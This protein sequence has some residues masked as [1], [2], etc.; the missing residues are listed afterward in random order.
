MWKEKYS[1]YI[2]DILNTGDTIN[3]NLSTYESHMNAYF[4][5]Y[6]GTNILL[7]MGNHDVTS[8]NSSKKAWDGSQS[9]V[10]MYDKYIGRMDISGL[11]ITQPTGAASNGYCYYYKDYVGLGIST[12]GIRL[13]VIDSCITDADYQTAQV[14][15]FVSTALAG[16]KTLGYDVIVA[17]HYMPGGCD[18]FDDAKGFAYF[19]KEYRGGGVA[20]NV[21]VDSRYMTAIDD[22][23]GDGGKFI[24]WLCGHTHAD[25]VG[26]VP[27]HS[28]Q[29]VIAVTSANANSYGPIDVM[30]VRTGKA[31]DAF[32]MIEFDTYYKQVKLVRVGYNIDALGRDINMI[33]LD[34]QNKKVVV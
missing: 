26:T 30:P 13:I 14:S 34:Y 16:A 24:T 4:N 22:F 29:M 3:D 19:V 15:W 12:S 7:A 28:N 10:D 25:H 27:S 1:S 18:E 9:I 8:P 33:T 32:D 2:D 20:G 23:I 21:S 5:D 17:S 6:G 31:Q 11:G